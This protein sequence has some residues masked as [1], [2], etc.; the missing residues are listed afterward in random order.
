[1]PDPVLRKLEA[2]LLVDAKVTEVDW[3]LK[4]MFNALKNPDD[5][6]PV[7]LADSVYV[8]PLLPLFELP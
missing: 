5:P 2:E 4:E 1:M 8:E 3:G 6:A 7:V